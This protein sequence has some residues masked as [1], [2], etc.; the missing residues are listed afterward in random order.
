MPRANERLKAHVAE[1]VL[2][3]EALAV[4]RALLDARGALTVAKGRLVA[5]MTERHRRPKGLIVS[6]IA[7]S[8][9]EANARR[10]PLG[11]DSACSVLVHF[12]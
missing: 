6:P 4:R 9:P 11:N 5:G 7:A 2:L 10:E 1:A 12:P 8:N 3:R